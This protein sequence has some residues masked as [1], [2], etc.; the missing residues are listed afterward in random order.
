MK[1]RI[2][3]SFTVI[4]A[5]L[6]SCSP[7]SPIEPI[8]VDVSFDEIQNT[9]DETLEKMSVSQPPIEAQTVSATLLAVGDNLIH[10]VIYQQ[11]LTR[12]EGKEYQFFP[13]YSAIADTISQADIAYINQETPIA[14]SKS[15]SS[16]PLFNSPPELADTLSD[17]G[18]DVI[19][20]ANNHMLDQGV[21]G[22]QETVHLLS[23]NPNFSVIGVNSASPIINCNGISFGFVGFTQHTN[24]ISLPKTNSEMII[25]TDQLDLIQQQIQE[26]QNSVDVTVVSVHW[27]EEGSSAPT[28]Y[29][30]ELAQKLTEWGAD[31]II[32]T[33]PHVLQPIEYLTASNGHRSL[34]MYSLGNFV[35]AQAE[36]ANLVGGIAKLTIEKD[37]SEEI[38]II[39]PH[40]DFVV[41]QYGPGYS[42]LH[43]VP[44]EAYTDELATQHGITKRSGQ[45]LSP[46]YINELIHSVIDPE[47]LRS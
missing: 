6:C 44:L 24:G 11:A 43:L 45:S 47:F 8:S 33:H 30:K 18:F 26:I 1:Q 21:S 15:P 20:L 19:N 35:S 5:I 42:N 31:I 37:S 2:V 32:G 16:Y 9:Q 29:Q 36:R 38:S 39:N 28:P 4:I 22:L 12:G 14:S 3:F 23:N 13:V 27:G 10:D 34:V 7:R 46:D 41:T 40:I 17:I 25:Y